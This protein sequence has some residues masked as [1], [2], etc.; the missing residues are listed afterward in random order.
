VR[1]ALNTQMGR[2]LIG[3]FEDDVEEMGDACR[4][5]IITG[6]EDKA[7][8]AG[9]DLKER[10]GMTDAAWLR[11]HRIFERKLRAI[12]ECPVPVIA[13][14]NGAAYAGGCEMVLACDFAY[15]V[16]EARFAL[17]EVS[18]GIMPGGGGTQMLPRAIGPRRAK[19]VIFRAKPFS[20]AEALS[21]GMVNALHSREKLLD[22]VLAVAADIAANA[23]LSIRQAKSSIGNGAQM[24]LRTGLRFEI[25]AYNQLVPTKDRVEGINAFNERRKPNFIGQ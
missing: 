10:Q 14:V 5:I 23:P 13:A 6:A 22:E 21:W 15:A 18:L 4:C 17:T 12:L 8:C 25:E 24:D 1:N 19:E 20:A 7:F 2:E 16:P 11:Q 3:F 9:A